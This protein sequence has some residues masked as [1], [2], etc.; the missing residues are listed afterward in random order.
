MSYIE[1]K[2]LKDYPWPV[3]W[4]LA[5]QRRV[6]G[7]VLEPAYLWGRLPSVFFGM[8]SMLGLFSRPSFP[9]SKLMRSL[10]SIRVA[11]L[12]GCAFCVDLNAYHYLLEQGV[13]EKAEKVAHWRE[14]DSIFNDQEKALLSYAEQVTMDCSS[15]HEGTIDQLRQF[16]SN[17]EITA[18]TAW[19]AFQNMSAKFN[20]AL[21][22]EPHGFCQLPQ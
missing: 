22:A 7:D 8:L 13:S 20:A 2:P 17:D 4:V 1:M 11:Q 21:G 16:F 15:I 6:Y 14:S 12:N 9:I 3:R 5:R 19:I 18:L 10:V